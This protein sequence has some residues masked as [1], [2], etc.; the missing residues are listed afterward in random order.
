MAI[1]SGD[2]IASGLTMVAGVEA[3]Q[4]SIPRLCPGENKNMATGRSF[5]GMNN[6]GA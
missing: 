1:L 4:R 5:W 3:D 2:G 6:W